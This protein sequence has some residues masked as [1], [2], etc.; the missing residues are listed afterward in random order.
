MAMSVR[1]S[2]S[3][4]TSEKET[5]SILHN[6]EEA[7]ARIV[8]VTVQRVSEEAY[9]NPEMPPLSSDALIGFSFDGETYDE[10]MIVSLGEALQLPYA[11][12]A[13]SIRPLNEGSTI[14][15]VIDFLE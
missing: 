12:K 7:V 8:G 4:L 2:I 5:F 11:A 10:E 3:C 15:V 14:N 1:Y 9:Q 6:G 13:V